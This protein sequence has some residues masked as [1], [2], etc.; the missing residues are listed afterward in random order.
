[1]EYV[2]AGIL[3]LLAVPFAVWRNYEKDFLRKRLKKGSLRW[4]FYPAALYLFDFW[5]CRSAKSEL[6]AE[7]AEA[8]YADGL[9]K[10][11]LRFRGAGRVLRLWS[12]L[13]AAAAA[14]VILAVSG[15][16]ETSEPA[17]FLPRPEMGETVSYDLWVTGIDKEAEKVTVTVSGIQPEDDKLT[18]VFDQAFIHVSEAI[19]GNNH[20]LEEVRYDLELVSVTDYGIRVQWESL[21]PEWINSRGKIVSDEIPEEGKIAVLRMT[22]SYGSY[23][24]CYDLPVHLMPQEKDASYYY[25]LLLKMLDE[26][27]KGKRT[28]DKVVLPVTLEE[29][30][31]DFFYQKK[32]QPWILLLLIILAGILW[33][34]AD[35]QNMKTEYEERSRQL[36]RDYPSVL[37]K[38]SVMLGCGITLRGTW[39]RI[40]EGYQ[41]QKRKGIRRYVYEEMILVQRR[42]EAG[43]GEAAAYLMFGQRC[44]EPCYVR[45]GTYLDQNIR[46]GVSGMPAM[47]ETEMNHALEERRNLALRLGEQMNTRL[48]VPMILMLAVVIVV[49]MAP[50]MLSM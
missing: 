33:F 26:E 45:L 21:A 39:S 42:I 6:E 44:K 37:F 16:G 4:L 5:Y 18:E 2:F 49:L 22:L 50:A 20:S 46:Q 14:G 3:I 48:L 35:R 13:A 17:E 29:K 15:T 11:Q 1:M 34:T 28:E 38:L 31:I 27:D 8:I 9:P 40:T 41:E 30:K 24:A 19:S 47:L 32:E 36:V 23:Q 25:G 12:C 7:W 43:D 10:E